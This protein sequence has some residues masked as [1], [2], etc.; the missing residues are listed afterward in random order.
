MAQIPKGWLVK[1]PYK[2]I[3]RD[4]AIYF[5]ITVVVQIED[6]TLLHPDLV[7]PDISWKWSGVW[8]HPN[9]SETS[10]GK[11]KHWDVFFKTKLAST[12]KNLQFLTTGKKTKVI[13]LCN[14]LRN[15]PRAFFLSSA[16]QNDRPPANAP[17][18]C[19]W[20]TPA[21]RCRRSRESS[22][23]LNVEP[24][25]RWTER[26]NNQKLQIETILWVVACLKYFC[27]FSPRKLGKMNPIWRS[28]FSSGLKP[29]TSPC[30]EGLLGF[31]VQKVILLGSNISPP[32][33]IL[34]MIFLFPRWDMLVSWRVVTKRG[35]CCFG[36][37]VINSLLATRQPRQ[38][39]LASVRWVGR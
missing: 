35:G 16:S 13:N 3:C 15:H 20:N 12:K 17:G 9:N 29:P 7:H 31:Y 39:L 24:R 28:Y 19:G 10:S 26:C 32:K 38:Q 27:L 4:C 8:I 1:G 6:A 30:F 11:K 25:P 18:G 2:P 14:F 21:A 22:H 34:K 33:G 23:E 5:S 36:V 37:P